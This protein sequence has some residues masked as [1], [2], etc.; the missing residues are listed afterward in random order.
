MSWLLD[1]VCWLLYNSVQ[2]W[3]FSLLDNFAQLWVC[4]LH[5]NYIQLWMCWL[6]DNFVQFKCVGYL[7]KSVGY[8]CLIILFCVKCVGYSII[9]LHNDSNHDFSCENFNRKYISPTESKVCSFFAI[10]EINKTVW[11]TCVYS[12]YN[13]YCM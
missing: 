9:F 3:V 4:W 8:Q 11:Y 12:I 13:V 7:I 10:S 6:L 1:K 5:D 2:L